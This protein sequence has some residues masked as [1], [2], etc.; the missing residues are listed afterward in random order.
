MA[1]VDYVEGTPLISPVRLNLGC[2]EQRYIG[3]IGVD[4][5]GNAADVKHNLCEPLPFADGSVDEIYASHVVEHFSLWQIQ[6]I[7]QDWCRVLRVGGTFW[8]L[9]PD[10]VRVAQEYLKAV[11]RNDRYKRMVFLANM[12]GGW[13]NNE[14]IGYGEVHHAMYDMEFLKET[15]SRGGFHPVWIEPRTFGPDNHA[16]LFVCRK[17]VYTP[18]DVRV[19]GVYPAH[20]VEE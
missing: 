4:M 19:H 14:F 3:Y 5:E 11:R 10:G 15:L 2:G 12:H 1:H 16:L 18:M 7:L 13:T 17:G 20:L 6:R 9:V 8:G